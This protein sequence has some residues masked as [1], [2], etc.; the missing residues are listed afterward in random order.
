MKR[1]I[2]SNNKIFEVWFKEWLTSYVPSLVEK[3]KCF[4]AEKNVNIGDVILFLKSEQEFVCQFQYG[5]I[6]DSIKSRDNITRTV[7]IEYRNH[8]ENIK[9]CTRRGVHDLIIIH[10]IEEI[11]ILKELEEFGKCD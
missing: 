4:V 11:G 6:V 7:K 2:E 1:I 8:S 5:I 9:R 10:P 3:P